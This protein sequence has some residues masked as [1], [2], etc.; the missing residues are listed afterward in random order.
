MRRGQRAWQR[1]G[2]CAEGCA[3]L[4]AH[5][6]GAA[7]LLRRPALP[8]AD[9][10][11]FDGFL[12]KAIVRSVALDVKLE[13]ERKQ[14]AKLTHD[15]RGGRSSLINRTEVHEICRRDAHASTKFPLGLQR[16]VMP[17]EKVL[18]NVRG[19]TAEARATVP[20]RAERS[21]SHSTCRVRITSSGVVKKAAV[22]PARAPA[23]AP[24]AAPAREE[25]SARASWTRRCARRAL[26]C[27]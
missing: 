4:K 2:S 12:L 23:M 17:D 25:G 13:E 22:A 18:W 19:P 16:V 15:S 5:A 7:S 20:E 11:D 3:A 9:E 8:Q 1:H 24:S 26:T 10:N 21:P 27:S 6:P 14:R